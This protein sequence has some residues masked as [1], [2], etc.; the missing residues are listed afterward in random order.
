MFNKVKSLLLLVA[1]SMALISCASVKPFTAER[2]ADVAFRTELKKE[3]STLNVPVEATSAE[4]AK[5]MNQMIGKDIYKGSTKYSG[6]SADIVKNGAIQVATADNFIHL[7]IPISMSLRYGVLSSPAINFNLKFRMTARMNPDWKLQAEIYYTGLSDLLAEEVGIGMLTFKPRTIVEGVVQP[8]QKT[9]SDLVS[10]L[11]NERYP[12]R[13]QMTKTWNA[14]QKPVLLD[15]NYNAW[16][17]LTPQEIMLYPL[18]AQ[19]NQFKLSL[20]LKTYAELVVGPEPAATA[21]TSLPNLKLVNEIDRNFR[22][23]LNADLHYR[24]LVTIAGPH[25]LNKELGSDGKSVIIREMEL[26]GNGDRLVVRVVLTGSMEGTFYLVGRPVFNSQNNMFSVE[27][28][29]FEMNSKNVL[30]NS[31]AW[32]LKGTIR[33]RIQEK[34]VMDMTPKLEQSLAMARKAVAQVKLVENVY[35]KGTVKTIKL[36]DILVQ[37]DKLAIQ[38]YTEGESAI[39]F[40]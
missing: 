30:L 20:G 24:D 34:L 10:K 35:L 26:Y 9:L 18:Y 15:K 16:L 2:P 32:L 22:I 28:V 25:L 3:L 5:T 12:L 29:D 27:D 14:A 23:T 40:Q 1:C 39:S 37:K 17:K 31:A 33:S 38:V 8:V 11:I 19:N 6:L 4:L 36:N 7:T 13:A 21:P